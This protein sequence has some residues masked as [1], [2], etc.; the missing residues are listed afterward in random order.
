MKQAG[1]HTRW[2]LYAAAFA[3]PVLLLAAVYAAAG[4][5]W[6]MGSSAMALTSRPSRMFCMHRSAATPRSQ[7]F[8]SP[9]AKMAGVRV[10]QLMVFFPFMMILPFF[11][12]R[13]QGRLL[14]CLLVLISGDLPV[15]RV[16]DNSVRYRPL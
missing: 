8:F 1:A 4:F 14:L 13:S 7:L 15:F 12:C 3:A 2:K 6:A 16:R 11:F 9:I 5:A 10:F